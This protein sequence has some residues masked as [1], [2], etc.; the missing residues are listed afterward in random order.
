VPFIFIAARRVRSWFQHTS[1]LALTATCTMLKGLA[2]AMLYQYRVNAH[3]RS[4]RVAD[5]DARIVY[6][7]PLSY[8]TEG[9]A[10][11]PPPGRVLRN[12]LHSR[13]K[14]SGSV[15]P[16]GTSPSVPASQSTTPRN[17]SPRAASSAYAAPTSSGQKNAD[18]S[19]GPVHRSPRYVIVM[20][21]IR[22][23][24]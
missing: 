5:V 15:R 20:N 6:T 22:Q 11:P 2:S 18:R 12:L 7:C 23:C 24:K 21:T 4:V 9:P 16:G 1:C 3:W 8:F 10:A 13:A 14:Y 17:A 19:N